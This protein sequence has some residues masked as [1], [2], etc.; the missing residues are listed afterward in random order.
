MKIEEMKIVVSERPLRVPAVAEHIPTHQ[1]RLF[2]DTRFIIGSSGIMYKSVSL[3]SGRRLV[4][5]NSI[6]GLV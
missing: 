2:E 5:F 4:Y 3:Q 1:R 6:R